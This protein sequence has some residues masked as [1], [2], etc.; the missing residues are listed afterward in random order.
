MMNK[1]SSPWDGVTKPET[2]IYHKK[3]VRQDMIIPC[4]W[5]KDVNGSLLFLIEIKGSHETAFY[6]NIVQVNGIEI[7]LRELDTGVQIVVL[8]LQKQVDI[9]LFESFCTALI[10]AMENVKTPEIALEVLFAHLN[11]WK[12]FLSG[13]KL[14][15]SSE[16]I[17]GLYAELNFLS[18]LIL[19]QGEQV[20][21]D[22][23]L[24]PEMA[25]H[26]FNFYSNAVEIKALSGRERNAVEISSEDQLFSL[27]ENLYLRIYVLGQQSDKALGQ[28]LNQLVERVMENI[29]DAELEQL[30]IQKLVEYGYQPNVEYDQP[31]LTV[32]KVTSYYV[33]ERFPKITKETIPEGISR[34]RYQVDL[35]RIKSSI[36]ENYKVFEVRDA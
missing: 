9:D 15:M 22:S 32:R 20:A 17:R 33:D 24:G 18:E 31:I 16:K 35:E 23:W 5:A 6:K 30:Y 26:D 27:N 29:S 34:V 4:H 7:D 28:S 1:K 14:L 25:Q 8:S 13:K 19:K 10:K 11:R 3:M 36:C 21:I 12:S 2:N